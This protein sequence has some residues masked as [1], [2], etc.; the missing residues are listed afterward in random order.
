MRLVCK[1]ADA[2]SA[3]EHGEELESSPDLSSP[4]EMTMVPELG[5]QLN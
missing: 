3:C 5:N 4:W 1:G 2:C